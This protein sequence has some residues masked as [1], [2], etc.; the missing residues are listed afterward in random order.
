MN[1]KDYIFH[2]K[3]ADRYKN[4][5]RIGLL[6]QIDDIYYFIIR[7]QQRAE[8]AYEKGFVGIPGFKPE[9]VYRSSEMFDFF[10]SRILQKPNTNACEEL[11]KTK[12]ISMIDSFSVEEAP[13]RVSKKYA[14]LILKTYDLQAQKLQLKE[15]K[16]KDESKQE[17]TEDIDK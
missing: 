12:G 3:W 15:N 17:E 14:E 10:K 9:E 2:V 7:S 13:E 1:K 8:I 5:Y 6:A 4:S 11:A 16:I